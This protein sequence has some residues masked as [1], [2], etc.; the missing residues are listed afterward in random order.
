[1][2]Q[3]DMTLRIGA[4][5]SIS[6]G[7]L[8]A[9]KSIKDKG[10]NCLQIFSSSPRTWSKS[11]ISRNDITTFLDAKKTSGVDPIFFHALYLINLADPDQTGKKSVE[12]LIHE[13]SLAPQLDVLGSIVHTGSFKN[14]NKTLSCRDKKNY[15]TLLTNINSVLEN[16]PGESLLILENA[17]NRKIG[18]T[19]DQLCEI[20]QDVNNPRIR[21]CLDTCHLH[22][23]E[24]DLRSKQ[25]YKRFL[26]EF[27]TKIGLDRLE[28]VHMNDSKDKL[29]DLRDRHENIGEG[30][31]GVEVFTNFLN[32][33]RTKMIPFIIETPG[34]DKQGPDKKNLDLLKGFVRE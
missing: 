19:I 2:I 12:A 21:V 28:V 26:D 8:N 7:L 3:C 20:I 32:D 27:D 9:I 4:H 33:P 18:Q 31:V 24:Y 16:T 30:Y 15:K 23:A 13:L 6:G 11:T 17:G 29:G 5:L 25:N 1:M 34:F 10:G 22:A 14:D